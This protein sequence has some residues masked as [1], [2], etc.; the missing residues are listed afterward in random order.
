MKYIVKIINNQAHILMKGSELPSTRHEEL[1]Y[2]VLDLEIKKDNSLYMFYKEDGTPD[3]EKI[4]LYIDTDLRQQYTNCLEIF[5]DKKAKE[6]HYDSRYT[7]SLR[8]TLDTS[9]FYDEGKAFSL[10]MDNCYVKGYETLAN[11]KAGEKLP[12]EEEFLLSMPNL[13]W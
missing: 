11:V 6:K 5:M 7:A 1:G 13:V 9:P 3:F 10:W 4:D 12:T 2:T 8:A